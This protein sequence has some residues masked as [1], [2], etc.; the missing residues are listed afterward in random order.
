MKRVDG[1]AGLVQAHGVAGVHAQA[2]RARG[3][4]SRV[5]VQVDQRETAADGPQP[6]AGR[7]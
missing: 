2:V 4:L 3:D 7:R 6:G 5:G 1:P